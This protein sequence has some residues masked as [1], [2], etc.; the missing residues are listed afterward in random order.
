MVKNMVYAGVGLASMTSEKVKRDELVEKGESQ[1]Q[2]AKESFKIFRPLKK[3]ISNLS[4]KWL[5]K[6]LIFLP[7][8]RKYKL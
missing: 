1:I 3:K 4:L 2:K 7:K 6:S 5:P 8:K